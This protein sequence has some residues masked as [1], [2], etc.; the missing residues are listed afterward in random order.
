MSHPFT[1]AV[2]ADSHF[3]PE[4]DDRQSAYPSDRVHNARNRAVVDWITRSGAE[5]VVHLG[6]VPHPVPG[7]DAHRVALAVAGETYAP[8][9]AR[10]HVVPGNHDVG[11]KPHPLSPAPGA[12]EAKHAVFVEHWGAP[13]RS[14]DHRGVHFVLLD[15]PVFNSG[16][17][18]EAEQ[19]AW[20]EADLA[21]AAGRRSFVFVHYPPFLL[22]PGEPEHYDNLAEPG[23]GRLLELLRRHGVEALF[24]GHVHHFFWHRLDTTDH[25]LLPSTAFMRPEYAELCPVEPGDEFGRNEVGRLG[26]AFVHVDAAGHRFE[27]V[28][29]AGATVATEPPAALAPGAGPTP[30]NPLGVTLRHRWDRTAD[31]PSDSLDPFR[32]KEAR[33]DLVVLALWDAGLTRVRLPAEDVERPATLTRLAALHAR[34]VRPVVYAAGVPT[35]ATWRALVAAAPL[36]EAVELILPRGLATLEVP[37][38][39][40]PVWVS[41][42]GGQK[43]TNDSYFSHF[44]TA[45]WGV[46]EPLDDRIPGAGVVFRVVPGEP[47]FETVARCVARARGLGRRAVCQVWLPRAT[48]GSLA[49]DDLGV[50][51]RV[52]EAFAAARAFPEA[53]VGVDTFV[54][55]DRGYY[56]RHGLLD[57]HG[58]P[59]PALTALRALARLAPAGGV[60]APA[61]GRFRFEA[62]TLVVDGVEG[63]PLAEGPGMPSWIPAGEPGSG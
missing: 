17:A 14:F 47:L 58:V 26:F 39:A 5:L 21:A 25:Y 51:R 59:R 7:L 56:P 15:T 54:D 36:L 57:R 40:P 44:P 20:L 11:D 10:L 34:G 48:E 53:W 52:A 38:G 27:P 62:G 32:R 63:L 55:H 12:T 30:P 49:G 9:G 31:L 43:P 28:R 37:E 1:F 45:G 29:T 24:A 13:W 8:L 35:V 6:D 61:P 22:D 60:A 16:S 50:A 42:G 46:D 23:R 19:W 33:N 2:I 18:R 3:H 41:V 4:A